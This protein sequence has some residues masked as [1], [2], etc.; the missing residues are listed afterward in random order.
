MRH[1]ITLAALAVVA[2][3]IAASATA[4]TE[5]KIATLAPDGS[6]WMQAVRAGGE[7]I[8]Q[9]TG[10]RVS[11][12]F[13][14]GGSMGTEQ[15]VLRKMRIGQLHGGALLAGTL[16]D[17]APDLQVYALP[18]TFRTYDQVDRVRRKFDAR[19]EHELENAGFV[20]FG[21]IEGGFAYLMSTKPIRSIGDLKGQ[22]AW[23]PEGDVIGTAILEAAGLSPVPLSLSDV[24]TGLQTGLIDV[25]AGPPVGAVALQWFTRVRHMTEVPII[26]TYGSLVI[27]SRAWQRLS[28]AD[29]AVVR[30]V[31][32]E[33]TDRLDAR[34]R[35]D[36]R[37]AREALLHQG[38]EVVAFDQAAV[39]QWEQIAA[40]ANQRLLKQ[41]DIDPELRRE[42]VATVAADAQGPPAAP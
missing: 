28:D 17:V 22:K 34:A 10:G 8:E 23:I 33:V 6:F 38:V 16:A 26:Y 30:E 25:V 27:S 18:L 13:Y 42:V 19:L 24:L 5:F 12:R 4:A 7:Q 9:R 21:F 14:P 29:Q 3:S 35:E 37:G 11:F 2:L 41:I 1:H 15:S 20:S 36:N 31:M 40:T 39:D 32:G